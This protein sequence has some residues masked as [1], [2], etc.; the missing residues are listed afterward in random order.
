M[1]ARPTIVLTGFGPFPGTAQNATAVLVPRLAAA[2]RTRFA[3]HDIVGEVLPTE[4]RTAPETLTRLLD[5]CR[6]V[7][8][9]HFGVSNNADGFQVELIGRN[10]RRDK[11]DAAGEPPPTAC[12]VEEAPALLASTLP[13]E[14]I[15]ARLSA[16]G[17]PCRASINAGSYLCNALLYHSLNVAR[18]LAQ[19]FAAG[20]VHVPASLIGHGKDRQDAHP[21][22]P[23]DWQSA[24]LGGLEIIAA[25]L[26][27]VVVRVNQQ[28]TS[29]RLGSKQPS[30]S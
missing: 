11:K 21:D 8:A 19:P 1:P 15:V 5:G 9:L 30:E 4:W 26:E 27:T 6:A 23:L 14:Y 3:E 2:A 20:F 28:R 18:N 24:T 10:V 22:C 7:L 12:V 16:L 13:A 25:S 17:L 29:K